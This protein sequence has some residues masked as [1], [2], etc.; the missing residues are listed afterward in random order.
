MRG[1][2]SLLLASLWMSLCWAELPLLAAESAE[3]QPSHVHDIS[4]KIVTEDQELKEQM[5]KVEAALTD[6]HSEMT[7]R[8]NAIKEETDP[9]RKAAL[10]A[11][12]DQIRE[13]HDTLERLL[14]D[15]VE[16]ATATE[17][18]KIDEALKRVK[19]IE[20][21]QERAERREEVFRDRKE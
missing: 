5:K 10:Y 2:C 11:E 12:L 8:R 19:S 14:H 20:R 1:S 6:L 13:E 16:E 18:T 4:S 9:A 17:W 7:K 15:L 21:Y 3:E